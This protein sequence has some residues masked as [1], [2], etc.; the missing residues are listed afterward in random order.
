[1]CFSLQQ[2]LLVWCHSNPLC[3][4]FTL[5]CQVSF[6]TWLALTLDD[7]LTFQQTLIISR[8]NQFIVY[9][10]KCHRSA[11]LT[12]PEPNVTSSNCFTARVFVVTGDRKCTQIASGGRKRESY[13]S[14]GKSLAC[15]VKQL[16]RHMC[17]KMLQKL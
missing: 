5:H 13:A 8:I 4:I 6:L 16:D 12:F 7:I 10:M 2:L 3:S 11:H 9:S 15:S 1:M 17:L 14:S